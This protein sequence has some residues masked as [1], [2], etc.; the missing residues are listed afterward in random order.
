MSLLAAMQVQ[1]SGQSLYSSCRLLWVSCAK[2]AALYSWQCWSRRFSG[3]SRHPL[4][5][6][7]G[8]DHLCSSFVGR[9]RL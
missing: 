3:I 4:L 6:P 1:I 2:A 7:L 5:L 8:T 9:T